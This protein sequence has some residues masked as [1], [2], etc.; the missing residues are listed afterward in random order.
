M[1][2]PRTPPDYNAT[3]V[4]RQDITPRL[5]IFRV[6]P[7]TGS[8]AFTPGQ[9]TVLGLKRKEARAAGSDPEEAPPPEKAERLIRRAYSISSSSH[10]NEFIEFYISLVGSGELTPRLFHLAEGDR[11]FMGAKASGHFTLDR[12]PADKGI[13]MIATG[14]GLAPYVSMLRSHAEACPTQPMAILHGASYSWDLGY[15]GELEGIARSCKNVHYFPIVSRPEKDPD[16]QGRT[17]RLNAWL[18]NA[19]ELEKESFPFVPE[20]AHVFLCGNPGMI[21]AALE[22]FTQR[23]FDEG[24]KKEPGDLHAEKYW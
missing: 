21:M 6:Q 4:E 19:G 9:F 22:T 12:A 20:R 5:A 18:D 15:R 3:L 2:A 24:T 17:G 11:L 7:D 23:G 16:W 13:L 8:L 14:T 10:D 1:A